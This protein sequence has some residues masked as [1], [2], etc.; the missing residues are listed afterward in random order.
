[1]A[2]GLWSQ[3]QESSAKEIY[4]E[5]QGDNLWEEVGAAE[6]EDGADDEGMAGDR[7]GG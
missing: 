2:S 4:E 5:T 1:M 3:L 6:E 7:K